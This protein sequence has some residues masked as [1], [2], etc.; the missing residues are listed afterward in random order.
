MSMDSGYSK[1]KKK[2]HGSLAKRKSQESIKCVSAEGTNQE[3][4]E[5]NKPVGLS[6]ICIHFWPCASSPTE[7]IP[8]LCCEPKEWVNTAWTM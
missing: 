3:S 8:Q 4:K 5:E 6:T 2:I 1:K 7:M